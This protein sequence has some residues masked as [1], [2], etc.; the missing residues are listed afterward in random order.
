M[1][2]LVLAGIVVLISGA[3]GAADI[4]VKRVVPIPAPASAPP[5]YLNWSGFYLGVNGG[6]EG[7][8]SH[9]NFDGLGAMPGRFNA[10]GWQVGGTAGY[11]YQIGHVVLGV[12][13]DID[14]SNLNGSTTCPVTG[15][16]CQTQNNWLGTVRGRAGYA[17]DRF[18]PYVTGGLAVG[19]IISK[20]TFLALE[21]HRP[22]M[23]V[24]RLAPA[25]NT[26][27]AKIGPQRWNTST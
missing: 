10:S 7:G 27:S 23:S 20:P 17:F 16:T 19:D 15:F 26:R 25:S 14:W 24:G 4:P 3:A 18:L 21:Q 12:E 9:F 11:N 1:R 6:W 5:S 2:A 8:R 13:S 22:P